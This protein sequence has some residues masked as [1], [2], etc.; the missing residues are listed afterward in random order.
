MP[1]IDIRRIIPTPVLLKLV[2][3]SE[4]ER[5]L[6]VLI[7]RGEDLLSSLTAN[8]NELDY[9]KV[10]LEVSVLLEQYGNRRFSTYFKE[11]FEKLS[12]KEEEV[13]K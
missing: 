11:R 13:F 2:K 3:L 4:D 10:Y 12:K 6:E 8:L 5:R 7:S 9:D 1:I